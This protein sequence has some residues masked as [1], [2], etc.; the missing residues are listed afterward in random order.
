MSTV[1]GQ[2]AFCSNENTLNENNNSNL[3]TATLNTNTNSNQGNTTMTATTNT[4]TNTPT[5]GGAQAS[6]TSAVQNLNQVT[7]SKFNS[8]IEFENQFIL[9]MPMIKAENGT[10]QP[11]PATLVLREALAS[12]NVRHQENDETSGGNGERKDPLKDR[13]FIDLNVD[14]RKGRVKFD[15]EIFEARL[16]D[17]PCIV[18][19]LKT[20][21]KKTFYKVVINRLAVLKHPL[22]IHTFI[23]EF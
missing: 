21:D 12:Q 20:T 2:E 1:V 3:L 10:I 4:Q 14:T 15:N 22:Q 11:H 19:S 5:T 9:R 18:E 16:V 23:F 17:L 13:L 7:S 6:T 8:Y